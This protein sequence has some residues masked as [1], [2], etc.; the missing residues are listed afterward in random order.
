MT[1]LL[2]LAGLLVMILGLWGG[3]APRRWR[4]ESVPPPAKDADKDEAWQILARPIDYT[5]GARPVERTALLR[6]PGD[7]QFRRGM[8]AGVG[9]GLVLA[10]VA[11]AYIP[12]LAPQ[13]RL[14]GETAPP[15]TAAPTTPTTPAPT[16]QKPGT[17]PSA[18]TPPAPAPAKPAKVTFVVDDGDMPPTVAS[19]LK[20]AGLIAD[21]GQFLSRLAERGVD[22]ALKSGT[23]T[24]PSGASLDQ[25]IDV[26]TA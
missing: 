21:E 24:I 17:T 25:V 5:A 19:K 9:A 26:L 12:V 20:A 1:W 22:T 4:K 16:A 11:V 18:T 23:F 13:G 6:G 3:L 7:G 8:V 2:V 14:A 10:G 15:S